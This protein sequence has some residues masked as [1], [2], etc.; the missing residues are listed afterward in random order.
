MDCFTSK[1]GGGGL[2][3]CVHLLGTI[4]YVYT[5]TYIM[6]CSVI[7]SDTGSSGPVGLEI[8]AMQ[9]HDNNSSS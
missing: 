5:H 1:K 8:H 9:N 4:R 7:I 2:L 3:G 6:Y